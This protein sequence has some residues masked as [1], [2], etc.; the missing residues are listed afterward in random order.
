[1]YLDINFACS[2]IPVIIWFKNSIDKD[3]NRGIFT[4]TGPRAYAL[5][6]SSLASWKGMITDFII[7]PFANCDNGGK[8]YF[9]KMV[10][11]Y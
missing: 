8:E 4:Y 10:L 2:N 5:G 7:Q 1:M 3:W 6:M 11:F 9:Y